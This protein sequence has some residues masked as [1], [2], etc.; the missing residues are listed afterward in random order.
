MNYELAK[1]IGDE[2]L[3]YHLEYF[4]GIREPSDGGMDGEDDLGDEDD[5]EDDDD[6]DDAPKK[7]ILIAP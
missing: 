4:L 7:V 2:L 6:E 3:P 5:D 1:Q